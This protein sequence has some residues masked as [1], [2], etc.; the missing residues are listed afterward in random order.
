MKYGYNYDGIGLTIYT[1]SGSCYLQYEDA[2]YLYDRLEDCKTDKQ[3]ESIL[4]EYEHI[5]E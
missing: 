3:I 4:S 2:H 1:P 5:C